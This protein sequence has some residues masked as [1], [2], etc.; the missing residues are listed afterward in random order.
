MDKKNLQSVAYIVAS[1]GV[2]VV[3][4]LACA[5]SMWRGLRQ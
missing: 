5:G 4:L 2:V 3:Y 1:A